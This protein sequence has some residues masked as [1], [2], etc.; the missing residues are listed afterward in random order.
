MH[1]KRP[2]LRALFGST[3]R[4]EIPL[5]SLCSIETWF[6]G[7]EY[8]VVG[9]R[10][11]EGDILGVVVWLLLLACSLMIL[12]EGRQ[13]DFLSVGDTGRAAKWIYDGVSLG[14]QV[15][16]RSLAR[17]RVVGRGGPWDTV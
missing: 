15:G 7:A 8:C 10:G 5:R 12:L 13:K 16:T 14:S 2:R 11:S 6:S 1:I 3:I 9:N 4:I 17:G